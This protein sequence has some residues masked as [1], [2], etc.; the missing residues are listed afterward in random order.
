[1]VVLKPSG[2]ATAREA[3]QMLV[4]GVLDNGLKECGIMLEDNP[5]LTQFKGELSKNFK[6]LALE[7]NT[8]NTQMWKRS[9]QIAS[10]EIKMS[11]KQKSSLKRAYDK[12]G[13]EQMNSIIS[14]KK[15]YYQI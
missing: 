7:N 2:G 12:Q 8:L 1:M 4:T 3:V 6:K 9:A 15:P 13:Q 10:S 11:K 14:D 5:N